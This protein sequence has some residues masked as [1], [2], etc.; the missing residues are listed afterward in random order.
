MVWLPLRPDWPTQTVVSLSSARR[1][2]LLVELLG[3]DDPLADG[4]ERVGMRPHVPPDADRPPVLAE[5]GEMLG[6][7]PELGLHRRLVP[8]RPQP[9]LQRQRPL[10]QVRPA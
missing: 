7:R 2:S 9:L 6:V 5:R 4:L 8:G 3:A 10:T 1:G